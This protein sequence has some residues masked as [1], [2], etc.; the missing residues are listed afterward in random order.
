MANTKEFTVA[1]PTAAYDDAERDRELPRAMLGGTRTMRDAGEQYLPKHEGENAEAYKRRLASAVLAPFYKRAVEKSVASILAK[2]IVLNDDVPPV[3]A[4]HWENIDLQGNNGDVFMRKVV[5]DSIGDAGVSWILIDHPPIADGTTQAQLGADIRPFWVHVRAR[6][7]INPDDY[8]IVDGVLTVRTARIL[9]SVRETEGEW[10]VNRVEQI[11]VLR[12]PTT[13]DG[14]VTW[15]LWRKNENGEWFAYTNPSPMRP[16]RKIPLV[17]VYT[18]FEGP[19]RASPP[20]SALADMNLLHYQKRSDIDMTLHKVSPPVIHRA[21]VSKEEVEGQMVLEAG[22]ILWST[23]ENAKANYLEHSG[24]SVKASQEDVDRL[25][26]RMLAESLEPHV[27]RTG[28]DTATGRAI[29]FEQAKTEIQAWSLGVK[30]AIE[31]ALMIHAEYLRKESGGSVSVPHAA[32]IQRVEP[33]V[34]RLAI[35]E[36]HELGAPGDVIVDELKNRGVLTED[37]EFDEAWAD[38]LEPGVEGEKLSF[39]RRVGELVGQGVD[40]ETALDN[41]DNE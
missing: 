1:T 41:A 37:F 3:I 32:R 28:A 7:Y 25:E 2:P 17:P 5:R 15:E 10:K 40:L 21:G 31:W 9:E 6:D 22:I 23:N 24:S 8:Q 26:T 34:L 18:N 16:M 14:F 38:T 33:E 30:D 19:Q 39:A 4:E 11:R 35:E 13:A 29:D 27:S 12:A 36:M 20:F